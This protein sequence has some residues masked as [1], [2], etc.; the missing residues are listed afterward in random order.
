ME[1]LEE[2]IFTNVIFNKIRFTCI[3]SNNI[4]KDCIAKFID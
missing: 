1:T 3:I 2:A 4:N